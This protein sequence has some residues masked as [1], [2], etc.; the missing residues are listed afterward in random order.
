VYCNSA[1][2]YCNDPWHSSSIIEC[3]FIAC[4]KFILGWVTKLDAHSLLEICAIATT[5]SS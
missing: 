3:L 1:N 5:T 4:L 2:I